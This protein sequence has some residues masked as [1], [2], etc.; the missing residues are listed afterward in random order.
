MTQ[1]RRPRRTQKSPRISNNQMLMILAGILSVVL[2]VLVVIGV[3]IGNRGAANPSEGQM[4]SVPGTTLG[5]QAT[6]ST[7]ETGTSTAPTETTVPPTTVPPTTVPPTTAPPTTVPS[8]PT[9]PSGGNYI[10]V[11]SGYV[12]EV[13]QPN[14]ETFTGKTTDDYSL[15]TNNYLPLGTVDY[16][17]RDFVYG[18][19][20]KY[21]L[22][23]SGHRVYAEKKI[24]PPVK[25]VPEVKQY[26]GTLPDHNEIGIV[27]M[28]TQ[29]K[30]SVLTL[31]C[32]W[33]APFYFDTNQKGYANP[34]GGKDR[35]FAVAGM[36]ATYVDITFCYATQVTGN[37]S[38]PAGHPL[39]KSAELI[40]NE[41]DYTLRL[42]LRK[43]GGFYG[44]HAYYNSQGQLCFQFLN[45]A[46]ATAGDNA[47][48][49]NLSGVTVMIDVGHG[50]L[51][52]GAVGKDAQNQEWEEAYLNLKLAQAVRKELESTGATVIFNREEDTSININARL[53]DLMD[54]SPDVCI[55][56]H[57]NSYSSAK[58][59]GFDAMYYTPWSQLLAK[60]IHSQTKESGIYTKTWLKW[61]VNYFMMRQTVCPVVLTENGYLSNLDDLAAML[62]DTKVQAKAQA[63]AK[64]VADYFLTINK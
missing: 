24:Y 51:D 20:M 53:K 34:S 30:H 16:C 23:R 60:N 58:V 31:N 63:I 47:Y 11:G 36:N 10:N 42:Y 25:I 40:K 27:S 7:G 8:M 21:V 55:A 64:G 4:G 59:G 37:L 2:I 15:P 52:G 19:N 41:S 44:W 45:P 1:E 22:L 32:L 48:G 18:S 28:E 29:G 62:D 43:T 13:I 57:Q 38:I 6:D 49:A 46:K 12:V 39:F 14:V 3:S 26:E 17:S 33:K 35:D 9:P 5:S 50:G 56:I 61:S 54:K